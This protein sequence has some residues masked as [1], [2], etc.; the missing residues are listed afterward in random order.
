[1]PRSNEAVDLAVTVDEA[2][3]RLD[4][5]V[6]RAAG[7]HARVFLTRR[8]RR[9]AVISSVEPGAA[10]LRPGRGLDE[11]FFRMERPADPEGKV[12]AGFLEDRRTGR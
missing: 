10:R 2:R 4:E 7:G 5:L 1:M 12:L 9:V 6:D 11:E 3:D 8:G